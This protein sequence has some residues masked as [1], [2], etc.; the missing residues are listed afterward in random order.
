MIYQLR[1]AELSLESYRINHSVKVQDQVDNSIAI[2][3]ILSDML[4]LHDQYFTV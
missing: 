4:L 3:E 1:H 2:Y